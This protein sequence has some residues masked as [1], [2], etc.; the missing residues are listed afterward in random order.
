MD[1]MEEHEQQLY[2]E[3]V[4]VTRT[5]GAV[6]ASRIQRSMRL[7]FSHAMRLIQR[8]EAHGVVS[9]PDAIGR[10]TLLVTTEASR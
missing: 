4:R 8:M 2:D 10:R 9:A 7:G 6:S 3:A 5:H 1:F